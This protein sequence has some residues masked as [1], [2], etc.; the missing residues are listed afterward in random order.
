MLQ[1]AD[2]YAD[3]ILRFAWAML[4]RVQAARDDI[5]DAVQRFGKLQGKRAEWSVAP[6][7]SRKRAPRKFATTIADLDDFEAASYAESSMQCALQHLRPGIRFG[8]A[9]RTLTNCDCTI[10]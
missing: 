9:R 4:N 1:H 2:N 6:E 3:E 8:D 5:A 10:V 7:S